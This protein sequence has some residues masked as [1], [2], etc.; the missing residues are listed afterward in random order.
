MEKSFS[1]AN[2]ASGQ[3]CCVDYEGLRSSL[4]TATLRQLSLIPTVVIHYR[5]KLTFSWLLRTFKQRVLQRNLLCRT[6]IG[7]NACWPFPPCF[8]W[9][10]ELKEVPEGLWV[11]KVSY[12]SDNL[13]CKTVRACSD[14]KKY[15]PHEQK[16]FSNEVKSTQILKVKKA[17]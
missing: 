1:M 16:L 12:H 2:P 14:T 13:S 9:E 11:C 10:T 8:W 17:V 15:Q 4:L 7:G 6:A 5:I 3:V